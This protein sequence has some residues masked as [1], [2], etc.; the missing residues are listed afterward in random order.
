[1]LQRSPDWFAAR[2]GRITASRL[3]DVMAKTKS[4]YSASRKNYMMELICQRLTGKCEPGFTSGPMMRG[5]EL[6]PLAREMYVLNQFDAEV[7]EVGFIP[8]PAIEWF[9]A[10]PDGLVNDDGLI[11]IKCPN[12]ATH[13][14]TMR[15]GKPKREYILQMHAQMMCTGRNWCDFVSFDKDKGMSAIRH[16]GKDNLAVKQGAN[17]RAATGRHV[18]PQPRQDKR[19]YALQL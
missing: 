12:T 11:E 19:G 4:G 5:T 6:E 13:I 2:C 3:A 16:Q 9:G 8:H 15:T 18:R 14:E 17:D 1:M 7:T 10:S